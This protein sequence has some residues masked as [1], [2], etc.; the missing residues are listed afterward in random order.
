MAK[1]KNKNKKKNESYGYY[2]GRQMNSYEKYW[3]IRKILRGDYD[4]WRSFGYS[5]GSCSGKYQL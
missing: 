3:E 4:N 2:E 5:G 1:K